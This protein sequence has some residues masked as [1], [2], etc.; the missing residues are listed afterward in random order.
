[1]L[2]PYRGMGLMGISPQ[3]WYFKVIYKDVEVFC[4]PTCGYVIPCENYI[5]LKGDARGYC[6]KCERWH[7]DPIYTGEEP[8]R[9]EG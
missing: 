2:F 5:L 1:M 8:D 4:C 7:R 3:R 6:P 9:K